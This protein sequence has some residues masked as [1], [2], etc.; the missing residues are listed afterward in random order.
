MN[1]S[2]IGFKKSAQTV[3]HILLLQALTAKY[4]AKE[5]SLIL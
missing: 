1:E 2:Q 5:I 3:E 4:T